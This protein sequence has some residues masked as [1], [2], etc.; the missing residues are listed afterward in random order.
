VRS[1]SAIPLSGDGAL[2]ATIRRT[3][4]VRVLLAAALVALLVTEVALARGVQPRRDIFVP[5]GSDT[6]VVVDLS[7]SIPPSA[8]PTIARVL[9]QLARD[10]VPIG[11]VIFSDTPYE[12]LPPGT[13][14]RELASFLRFFTPKPGT[15][16]KTVWDARFVANP[17]Q[18]DFRGGTH[19]S[20]AL[21]LADSM[22]RRDH[23]RGG[24]ILLI[25]DLEAPSEDVPALTSIINRLHDEHRPLRVVGLFPSHDALGLFEQ[26]AGR[27]AFV[28][29][30]KAVTLDFRSHGAVNAISTPTGMIA[31][32]L[33]L[34]LVLA[35]NEGWLV[36]LPVSGR[37]RTREVEQ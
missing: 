35:W 17:W 19:I 12:L 4:A 15:H 24:A 26:L 36:R 25:S 21:A 14:S 1:K 27:Q 10:D 34:L 37:P 3:A 30:S 11:F 33:A 28:H 6:V 20:A 9:G 32:G 29:S 18:R 5:T 2:R 22:L 8:F 31:A 23:V 13:P 7:A 16:P